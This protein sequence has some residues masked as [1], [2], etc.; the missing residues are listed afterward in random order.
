MSTELRRVLFVSG[1]GSGNTLRY[2]VRL[3]EEA[4]RS[5]GVRTTAVHFT[6][7]LARRWA[8]GADV[9]ALYRT[10]ATRRVLD[11]VSHARD[12]LGIPVTFDIDDLVFLPTHLSSI[13]FLDDLPDRTRRIFEADVTRRGNVVPFVDRASGT[14]YPVVEDLRTLTAAPVDVVPN[15]VSRL[16]REI[17]AGTVRRAPDGRIRLGYFSGSATHDEDWREAEPAVL[18][19]LESDA[20]VDLWLVGPLATGPALDRF[21]DRVVRVLPVPW[22]ELPELLA[23][24]DINLAPLDV[25]PFTSGKSAIKWLEAALVGTPTIATA[26]PPFR[27]AVVDGHSGLLVEPGGDWAAALDRLVSD[28]ALRASVGEGAR[29]AALEGYSPEVQAERYHSF[30][31]AALDGP[32][33]VVDR[34]ALRRVR[35]AE[36][37]PRGFGFD[38]EAYPFDAAATALEL[39]T[40]RGADALAGTRRSVRAAGL[41][42]RRYYRGAVRRIKDV[43]KTNAG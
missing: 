7:P 11:L 38:L 17:A 6:D 42:G 18:D 32:R 43:R 41:F 1:S 14:T 36:G 34:Q 23:S 12:D 31:T 35:D 3:A 33:A 40:P 39:A 25:T 21:G 22:Q 8:D 29:T 26:T 4:L 10:P 16:G 19:L 20:R 27:D 2:R 15:G 28:N 13:P 37:L 24:V 30:F 5:R 9:V